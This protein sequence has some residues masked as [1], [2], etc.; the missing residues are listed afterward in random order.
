MVFNI[1]NIYTPHKLF[2]YLSNK[3]RIN[4]LLGHAQ[5]KA[6]HCCRAGVVYG[7]DL[8]GLLSWGCVPVVERSHEGYDGCFLCWSESESAEVLSVHGRQVL[9]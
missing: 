8:I 2:Q 3:H 5:K 6:L 4:Q 7:F 9:R 1:T